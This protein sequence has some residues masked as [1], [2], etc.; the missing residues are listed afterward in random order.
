[1]PE[2]IIK[3]IYRLRIPLPQS[4]LKEL[5]SYVIKGRQRNLIIDTGMR[6]G[7]CLDAMRVELDT[8]G[9]DLR[10]TDFF[11]TH[12]HADHLGLV[13][14][15]VTETGKI[16]LNGP[17][18]SRF[19]PRFTRILE[20]AARLHGFPEDEL[21]RALDSH[22]GAKYGPRLPLRLTETHDGQIIEA[23]DYRF[24]CV[25]T[26][27]HSFGHTC[28]YEAEQKMLISGDH[29]LDDITPNIGAWRDDWNLLDEYL[30]SLEKAEA[31]DVTLVL[32]GHR[33]ILHD[34][35]RRIEQLKE[36]HVR[37]SEEVLLL[38]KGGLKTAYQVAG[39]M[40]WDIDCDSF[41]LFPLSQRWFAVGETIAHL[42]YLEG[43]TRVERKIMGEPPEERILW[44]LSAGT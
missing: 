42:Y 5:N 32:P 17:D 7:E 21:K 20:V 4:P 6:R 10:R 43:L 33:N 41:E 16:Y 31:L 8:L 44:A 37:R 19:D 27:G 9:I 29:I 24:Q 22:P 38:L 28:L 13:S 26:P 35:G 36:H 23:G 14:E 11:I 3:D 40:T 30:K 1:M 18:S 34:M 15:L 12:F 25:E 39:G 2:E